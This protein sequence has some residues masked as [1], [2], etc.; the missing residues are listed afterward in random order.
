MLLG[1]LAC[2]GE[3]RVPPPP[4]LPDAG[5]YLLL[6]AP[7]GGGCGVDLGALEP[8]SAPGGERWRF[9][10]SPPRFT[11]GTTVLSLQGDRCMAS[12]AFFIQDPQ[13]PSAFQHNQCAYTSQIISLMVLP[14]IATP[15]TYRV[16]WREGNSFCP[17][18]DCTRE[19]QVT[20]TP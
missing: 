1:A 16:Q 2:E 17:A 10:E 19:W 8:V 9:E 13:V 12:G 5:S 3:A 11:R 14:G 4:C 18:K 15:A 7:G 20:L 6:A